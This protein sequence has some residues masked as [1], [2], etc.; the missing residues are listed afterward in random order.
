MESGAGKLATTDGFLA[1]AVVQG[2]SLIFVAHLVPG[3][4]A[5]SLSQPEWDSGW[6]PLQRK[7]LWAAALSST[8]IPD[9]DVVYNVIFRGFFNHSTLYTHSL[10]IHLIPVLL[11]V[12]SKFIFNWRYGAMLFGLIAIGGLSHIA[13]DAI[14]HNTPLLYPLSDQMFGTGPR[15]IVEHGVVGYLTHPFMLL[16]IGMIAFMLRSLRNRFLVV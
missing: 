3:Y 16:E 2:S 8:V 11:W 9:A 7:V 10:L 13:L 15:Q 5:A 14:V 12:L 4:F 1:D 6:T